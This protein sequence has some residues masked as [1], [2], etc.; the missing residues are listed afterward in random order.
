MANV[1]VTVRVVDDQ[2][3]PA[4]VDG[5]LVR[6]FDDPGDT[7]ITEGIT[8]SVTP[9]E[10]DFTLFA[11]SGGVGYTFILSKSGVSFPPAPTKHVIAYDPPSPSNLFQ[12]TAHVGLEGQLVTLVVNDDQL[13][14]Q[15]VSGVPLLVFDS[16]DLFLTELT[17]DVNGQAFLVLDGDPDPGRTYIV[18]VRPPA[19]STVVDGPTKTIAVQDPLVAP[20]TNIFDFTL[21]TATLPESTNP[22]MCLMSGTLVDQALRPLKKVNLRF[23]PRLD[24]PDA[25]VSGY[26]FPSDP[27]IL[28]RQIL[29]REAVFQTANDGS[30]EVSLPRGAIYDVHIHSFEMPGLPTTAQVQIPDRLSAQ[31][32]DVLFPYVAYVTWGTDT[33]SLAP[34]ETAEVSL[35]VVGSNDQ[36]VYGSVSVKALLD[37]AIDD[38]SVAR[39][40][41]TSE[42]NVLIT[43]IAAGTAQL[44]VA[45]KPGTFAVRIPE[46]PALIIAPSALVT[47]TVA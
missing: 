25:K 2:A 6:V 39:Y 32:E 20:A 22:D 31:L 37:L 47:I 1:T 38:E 24:D 33:V 46:V 19:G 15:P 14:P 21:H 10:I 29:L 5:V 44:S 16:T 40:E 11:N 42:G 41:M 9:G 27:A 34:G 26:P 43:A 8:G 45:R 7:Y 12:F 35:A 13:V 4:L 3:I 36:G 18:R 23:M 28:Q 17:T 30:V